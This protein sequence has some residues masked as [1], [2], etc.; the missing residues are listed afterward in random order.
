VSCDQPLHTVGTELPPT[1]CARRQRVSG[2]TWVSGKP[3]LQHG[4]HIRTQRRAP[5]LV[6]SLLVSTFGGL[7]GVI[8]AYSAVRVIQT[9]PLLD[10]PR[11]DEVAVNGRMV[12]FTLVTSMTA[13]LVS[14]LAPAWQLAK[15]DLLESM[16]SR[17]PT[18]GPAK[19]AGRLRW[20]LVS[21]EVGMSTICLVAGGL[22]LHSFVKVLS[23]DPGFHAEQVA[24]VPLNVTHARYREAAARVALADRLLARVRL[25]H[26]VLSA[27]RQDVWWT[28]ARSGVRITSRI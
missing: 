17:S 10:V 15:T 12:L 7:A 28:V 16:K 23:V 20:L 26:G 14:G 3:C 2:C 21:L 27:E 9:S 1:A 5:M 4:D 11:L 22:L 13:G 19:N 25:V 6:E 8:D 24:S 18:V